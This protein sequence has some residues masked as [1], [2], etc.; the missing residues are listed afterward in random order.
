VLLVTLVVVAGTWVFVEL[1][2]AVLEGNTQAFD[3]WLLDALRSPENPE[4]PRGPR[5]LVE[6][7]RGITAF[8]SS[9]TVTLLA[10]AWRMCFREPPCRCGPS[11][12]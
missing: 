12:L 4:W 11:R 3:R 9:M 8:G 6:I 7:G 5:W 1:A 2:G 10:T